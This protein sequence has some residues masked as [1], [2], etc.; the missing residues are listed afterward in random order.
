M[1]F[2][3]IWK[4]IAKQGTSHIKGKQL[5]NIFSSER[6]FFRTSSSY[7]KKQHAGYIYIYWNT[8]KGR[9]TAST[10]R[11]KYQSYPTSNCSLI[12][13]KLQPSNYMHANPTVPI[14]AVVYRIFK[15]L[16]LG[17]NSSQSAIEDMVGYSNFFAHSHIREIFLSVSLLHVQLFNPNL[18]WKSNYD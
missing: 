3:I 15:G 13:G 1:L 10:H 8:V 5:D 6:L 12:Y 11:L 18:F 14:Y 2:D 4:L 7:R 16:G 9:Q 17:I